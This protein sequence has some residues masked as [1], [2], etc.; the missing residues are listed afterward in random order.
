MVQ[1]QLYRSPAYNDF[2]RL[3]NEAVGIASGRGVMA[4]G[5]GGGGAAASGGLF[6]QHDKNGDGKLD[7]NEL[8]AALFDRLDVNKDGFVSEEEAKALS[9]SKPRSSEPK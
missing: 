4:G 6:Q 9:T 1:T 8:P 2:R 5:G 3:V 7:R